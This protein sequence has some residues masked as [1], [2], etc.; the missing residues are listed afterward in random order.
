VSYPLQVY[1]YKGEGVH[2]KI[3]YSA[4]NFSNVDSSLKELGMAGG[5]NEYLDIDGNPLTIEDNYKVLDIIQSGG[6]YEDKPDG[7]WTQ[8]RVFRHFHDPLA[9]DKDA[10]SWAEAGLGIYPSALVWAQQAYQPAYGTYSCTTA[11]GQVLQ[12]DIRCGIKQLL[13]HDHFGLNFQAQSIM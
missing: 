12:Y 4:L 1:A 9:P 3:N 5:I 6:K 2:E 8:V 13:W 10:Q 11:R 7:W